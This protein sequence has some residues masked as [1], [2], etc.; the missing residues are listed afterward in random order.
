MAK[1]LLVFAFLPRDVIMESF[2]LFF[3]FYTC[4]VGSRFGPIWLVGSSFFL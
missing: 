1:Y 3:F 2:F 4:R